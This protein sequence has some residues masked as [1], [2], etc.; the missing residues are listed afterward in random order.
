VLG[1]DLV[2]L[3]GE[4]EILFCDASFIVRGEAQRHFVKANINVRMVIDFLSFPGDPVDKVHAP[5]ESL[6]LERPMNCLRAFRP[7]RHGFQVES[8][9]FGGEGRHNALAGVFPSGAASFAASREFV[10]RG[11]G[12]GFRSFRAEAPFFIAGFDVCRLALLLFSVTGFIALR[13][14]WFF[15][16]HGTR[17]VGAAARPI[18]ANQSV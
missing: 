1:Q 8:G 6:K 9:L 15:L 2:A 4:D 3:P 7:V 16:S 11:P 10:Y 17:R 14:G 12:P 18:Y 13:H 5:Q